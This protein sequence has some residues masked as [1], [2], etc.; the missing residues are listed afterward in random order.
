[1]AHKLTRG[2][3]SLSRRANIVRSLTFA[4]TLAMLGGASMVTAQQ[5]MT[6]PTNEVIVT[7][8]GESREIISTAKTVGELLKQYE[9]PF[10]DMDRCSVPLK[11]PLKDGMM[12]SITRI[13][14]SVVT[15]K[16]P[17][18]FKT[19]QA[20]ASDLRVGTRQVKTPGK[21]GEKAV[22]YRVYYKDGQPTEK[23]KL[24]V[25]VTQPRTEVVVVG[26]RGMTL[27]SRSAL[28]GRR[29][30]DMNASAYGPGGNGPWGMTTAM[31]IRPR[32]G[33]VAVDPRIIPLG[34]RL[35]V[36]GYGSALA[37]DTGSAIKGMRIDLFY[38]T[39]R[40]AYAYGRKRVKVMVL[41]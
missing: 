4:F 31:G 23:V 40:Q 14:T 6:P 3:I 28:G 13:H 36:E 21:Q 12:L 34:T 39:D 15:E 37:A 38:P 9:I 11:T 41:D 33:I 35:Y 24:G 17:L 7:A 25:K 10:G 1:M 30:L 5:A 32:Y 19:R 18:P 27:A 8:D 20:Y 29:I 2:T 26:V 16:T 22:T